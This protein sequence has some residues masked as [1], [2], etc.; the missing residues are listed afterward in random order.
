MESLKK[1]LQADEPDP[2]TI[3]KLMR[4]LGEETGRVAGHAEGSAGEKLKALADLLTKSG[5]DLEK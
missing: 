3:G 5:G 4:T 1:H 2:K